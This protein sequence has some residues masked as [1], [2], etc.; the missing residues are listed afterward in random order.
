M[1]WASSGAVGL[2]EDLAVTLQGPGSLGL[3]E[4]LLILRLQRDHEGWT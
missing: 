4:P 2:Y 1:A 3:Y